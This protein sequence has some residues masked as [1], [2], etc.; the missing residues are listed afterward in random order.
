MSTIHY[1]GVDVS[2]KQ[3]HTAR[4]GARGQLVWCENLIQARP[5][6]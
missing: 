6:A 4:L 5:S 3:L 1:V 2:A